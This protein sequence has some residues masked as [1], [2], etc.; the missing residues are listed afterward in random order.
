MAVI[1]IIIAPSITILILNILNHIVNPEV[2]IKVPI[3]PV[4][5]HGLIS[6]I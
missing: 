6:T 5:G 2:K 4:R 3:A 1:M